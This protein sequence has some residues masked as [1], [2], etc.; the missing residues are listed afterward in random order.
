MNQMV[1]ISYEE[2][3]KARARQRHIQ[4]YGKPKVVNLVQFSQ[5][6]E[7]QPTGNQSPTAPRVTQYLLPTAHMLKNE[8]RHHMDAWAAYLDALKD[9]SPARRFVKMQCFIHGVTYEQICSDIRPRYLSRAREL[10]MIATHEAFPDLPT[11]RLGNLINKNHTSVLK[12]LGR[13][14]CKKQSSREWREK[15]ARAK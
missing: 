13:L 11:T 3:A 4:L 12:Y 14:K 9:I 1:T 15:Q 7:P 5:V 6:V 8:P 2:Q 10:I